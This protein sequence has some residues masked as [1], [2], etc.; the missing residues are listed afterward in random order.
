MISCRQ[1]QKSQNLA[2]INRSAPLEAA[3]AAA[4]KGQLWRRILASWR[5]GQVTGSAHS[6]PVEEGLAPL[7]DSEFLP[8]LNRLMDCCDE[9]DADLKAA[10]CSGIHAIFAHQ[11]AADNFAAGTKQG[12]EDDSLD[13]TQ[14]QAVGTSAGLSALRAE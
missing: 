3:L 5:Q 6:I 9:S 14:A 12:R 4:R 1:P 11:A 10:I 7:L 13:P 8:L 2:D